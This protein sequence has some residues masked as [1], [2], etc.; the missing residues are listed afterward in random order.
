MALK[1][2]PDKRTSDEDPEVV[3]E[4]FVKIQLAYEVLS[5]DRK[6]DIYDRTGQIPTENNGI[7]DFNTAFSNFDNFFPF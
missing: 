4:E 1:K 7:T 2:H 6:R 3:K 5:D